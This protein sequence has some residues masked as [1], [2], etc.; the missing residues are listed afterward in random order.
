MFIYTRHYFKF[1]NDR[2]V[3]YMPMPVSLTGTNTNPTFGNLPGF[4]ITTDTPH[5][6][7]NGEEGSAL[8][9]V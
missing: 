6:V 3:M 2:S 4:D 9:L 7:N 8:R 1:L 5:S